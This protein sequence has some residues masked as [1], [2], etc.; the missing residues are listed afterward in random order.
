MS[1]RFSSGSARPDLRRGQEVQVTDG[2]FAGLMAI[3]ED[4]PDAQGRVRVL[5]RL[6]NRRPVAVRMSMR[7][8]KSDWVA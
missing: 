3:I 4:P 8:V 6:L 5:M 1:W 2:P 7:F